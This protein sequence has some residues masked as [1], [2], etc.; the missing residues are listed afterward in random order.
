MLQTKD[1]YYDLPKELIAQTP[2]EPRDSS[3]LLVYDRAT[4]TVQHKIFRDI[5]EFLHR[6]DL[7]VVNDTKVLPARL[8]FYTEH[9]G[10]VEILLLKR[11]NLTDWEVMVKPGKKAKEGVKLVASEELSLQV[12]SRTESGGRIVRFMYDGVFEDI[13]S[14]IGEMPL[15]PYIHEKLVD[16][17]RYQTVYCREE[18]SAIEGERCGVC[19]RTSARGAWNFQARKG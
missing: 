19:V 8:Y 6:G 1:F 12:L 14:R 13:I 4:D 11:Q 2:V 16:K 3:R 17:D 5:T 18:G 15:P 10:K 7:L 9:G